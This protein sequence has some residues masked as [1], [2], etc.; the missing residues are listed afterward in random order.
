MYIWNSIRYSED[1]GLRGG[2]D[3]GMKCES[4]S[5]DQAALT[6]RRSAIDRIER[7]QFKLRRF[8]FIEFMFC[9]KLIRDVNA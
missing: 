4:D 2:L 6:L 8:G 9:Q 3:K 1:S 5:L 7:A